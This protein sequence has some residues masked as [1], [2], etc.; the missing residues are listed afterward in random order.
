MSQ[1]PIRVVVCDDSSTVRRIIRRCL[2][3]LDDIEVVGE[4][5]D[6]IEVLPLI[7]ELEPD[8]LTLDIEMPQQ[9]GLSTLAQLKREGVKLPV[10]MI[11]T[12]THRG[13]A[14]TLEALSRGASEYIA[15]PSN[16]GSLAEALDLVRAQLVPK[17]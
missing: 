8:L 10:I 14:I 7:R 15:K 2:K 9:D 3:D 5:G 11:S 16:V 12:L 1:K 17:I 13:A 4:A 6:G